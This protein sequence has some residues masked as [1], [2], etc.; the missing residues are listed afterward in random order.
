MLIELR[1][2]RSSQGISRDYRF[3]PLFFF[4]IILFRSTTTGGGDG[5]C[6]TGRVDFVDQQRPGKKYNHL[7]VSLFDKKNNNIK[8]LGKRNLRVVREE[9]IQLIACYSSFATLSSILTG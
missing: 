4:I 9:G 1:V 3:S 8:R 2:F 7:T 6:D 5:R